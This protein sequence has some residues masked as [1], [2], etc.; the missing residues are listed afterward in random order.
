[1]GKKVVS[2]VVRVNRERQEGAEERVREGRHRRSVVS[3][4]HRA[5]AFIAYELQ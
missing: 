5:L 2:D 1:M 4:R 3:V